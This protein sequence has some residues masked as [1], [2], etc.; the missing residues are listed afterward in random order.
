MPND[1]NECIIGIGSNINPEKHIESALAILRQE[2][3]VNSISAWIKTTPIGITSQNDFINGA[4][5]V[6]T[7]LSRQAFKTYLKQLENRLGRDRTLPKFG[8]RVIDLDIIV[9]NNEI[10]DE[11]YYARDFVRSSVNELLTTPNTD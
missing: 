6:Q 3:I 2:V 8:P 1:T 11:D 7:P 5:K 10:V 9:W 4:I